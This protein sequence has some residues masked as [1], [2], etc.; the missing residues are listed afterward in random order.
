MIRLTR[1]NHQPIGLNSDL[2]KFIENTPDTTITLV[3]GEKIL[4]LESYEEI[5]QRI[6]AFRRSI[7]SG[8]EPNPPC[9]PSSPGS[10]SAAE[11]SSRLSSAD[12]LAPAPRQ[13]EAHGQG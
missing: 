10:L 1:L 13:E 9:A 6:V 2:I 5:L 8:P 7:L 4:V 3:S 12:P 11:S